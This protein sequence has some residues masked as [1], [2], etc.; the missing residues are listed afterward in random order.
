[1][2]HTLRM[3]LACL[4]PLALIFLLPLFGVGSGVT[5]AV[6]L[7]LMFVFHLMMMRARSRRPST[8]S[9]KYRPY[10][11]RPTKP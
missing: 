10:R 5:F 4:A 7:V 11:A 1:M 9:R 2:P 3:I 8:R 6:F